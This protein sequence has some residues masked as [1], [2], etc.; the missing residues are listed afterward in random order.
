PK[1][2]LRGADANRQTAAVLDALIARGLVL[3]PKDRS[4]GANEA[5]MEALALFD[6]Q[7][8]E[9][10]YQRNKEFERGLAADLAHFTE[11]RLIDLL[12]RAPGLFTRLALEG[13][14]HRL[15]IT[16]DRVA[17]AVAEWQ[18]VRTTTPAAAPAGGHHHGGG[19]S[20]PELEPVPELSA[21]QE[22]LTNRFARG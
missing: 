2:V 5:A 18:R 17:A 1:R 22:D 15:P 20:L 13:L 6:A 12:E 4:A 16:N 7:M 19:P 11:T 8:R 9:A 21:L 3:A 10:A 14:L